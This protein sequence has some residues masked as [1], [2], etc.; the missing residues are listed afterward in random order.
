MIA[1]PNGSGKSTLIAALRAD[2]RFDVPALYINA[3]DL[4]RERKLR[5]PGEAQQL[6]NA[7]RS[8]AIAK[9]QDVMYE[10][11]MSHPSKIAELQ[12]A[13][14]AGYHI[15]LLLVATE[16][17]N[18]NVQRVALRVAAGGHDV[19]EDRTRS[20]YARTLV[21]APVAIGYA[22][23]AF[24]FDNTHSGETGGGLSQQ[25]GLVDDRLV[26]SSDVS[27][28]WVVRLIK[29]VNERADELSLVA[30]AIKKVGLSPQLALLHDDG[31]SGEIVGIEKYFAVQDG[32]N[33]IN[34]QVIGHPIATRE[35]HRVI[36]DLA[37]LGSFADRLVNGQVINIR[38]H[39][40]VA[41]VAY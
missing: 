30:S 22:D 6:A 8:Q 16:H 39:E 32:V 7:L 20:R 26:A 27:A 14:K 24:I 4:Q 19:P 35:R 5:D 37:L 23:Q 9:R 2:S 34:G 38:Y 41:S 33:E 28:S 13:K 21:L 10:T 36:H 18:I 29:Q 1:G 15:T 40:G 11:V 12:S 25:A 3:D 31:M 17:P